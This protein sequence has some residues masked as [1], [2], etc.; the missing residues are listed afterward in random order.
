[1]TSRTK[2]QPKPTSTSSA[3]VVDYSAPN[4][5][6][7]FEER[8]R[9]LIR[10]E[11]DEKLLRA[12]KAYYKTHPWDFVS[13]WGMTF[14]PRNLENGQIPVMPFVLWKR[15]F[16]YLQWVYASWRLKERGLV[17]KS[18]DC[19]VSWLSVGF[20]C[21]MWLFWSGFTCKFG[22]RKEDLVDKRGDLDSIFERIWFFLDSLPAVFLPKGFGDGVRAHMRVINPETEA[23]ITGE[24][25]ENIGR[26][27]RSSIAFVDE[28]AFIDNQKAV[29]AALSQTTNC[30]IDISS[31]NGSG[32]EFYKKRQRF[33]NTRRVFVFD[34]RDDPRKDQAWYDK[35]CEELDEVTVASEIDR[36]YDASAEDSFLPAK[37][38]KACVDA[39]KRFGIEPEGIRVTSFDP[40]DTGDA[41]A[42]AN[43]HG[44]VILEA[45]QKKDGDI[46]DAVPWAFDLADQHR[47]DVFIYD[48]D[49]LGETALKMALDTPARKERIRLSNI[50][51]VAYHGSGA[52]IDPGASKQKKH[53]PGDRSP[54]DQ[55][56]NF[57]AQSWTWVYN[58]ML[59]TYNAIKRADKGQI[60]TID[61]G[62]LIS[63]SSECKELIQLL[64]EL[65]R[66]KR[67][68]HSGTGKILVES[69]AEMKARKVDSPN[70][71]DAVVMAISARPPKADSRP[72]VITQFQPS[73][74]G[75][76]Y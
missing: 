16:E 42:V 43:R 2:K 55:F 33:N 58:R 45:R 59:M 66:P 47:A 40:A 67:K 61:P 5:A 29:D 56:A 51:I 48:G 6:R 23:A 65:S 25:G 18:R 74:P 14:D 34:W 72:I 32:N 31:V 75:M 68:F 70:L 1:M 64:A 17:E 7:I 19:G 20:A 57:R 63:I 49:G 44:I 30:Q 71:A 36:D 3:L 28:A 13:D 60:V 12:T 24:A 53:N 26:G 10:L 21:S 38:V 46:T 11:G 41:K 37:M 22:S 50:K 73:D 62:M 69:K 35:Q 52:V 15:Q 4:Y 9:R 54:I 39:H 8:R 27:G 76:G